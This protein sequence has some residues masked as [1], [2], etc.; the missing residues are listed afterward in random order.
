MLYI[1]EISEPT[2]TAKTPQAH[3]AISEI[4]DAKGN[5]MSNTTP[6]AQMLEWATEINKKITQ[7]KSHQYTCISCNFEKDSDGD[8]S[9]HLFIQYKDKRPPYGK[10]I[11]GHRSI[12]RSQKE[13]DE[14]M[15]KLEEV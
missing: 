5:Q 13:Y 10:F 3:G 14:V 1:L 15:R 12:D 2:Q 4:G 6:T 9:I 7:I 8:I 11:W